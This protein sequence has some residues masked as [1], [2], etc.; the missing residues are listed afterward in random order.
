[1]EA[2][3][4]AEAEYVV[5]LEEA[6]KLCHGDACCERSGTMLLEPYVMLVDTMATKGLV[7]RDPSPS[8][9]IEQNILIT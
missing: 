6:A 5:A 4:I 3:C 8:Q 2:S 9:C 1:M 7:P